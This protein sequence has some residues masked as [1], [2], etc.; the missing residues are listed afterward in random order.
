MVSK[1]QPFDD[2]RGWKASYCRARGDGAY[3]VF[4]RVLKSSL[5]LLAGLLVALSLWCVVLFVAGAS[6][7]E[8]HLG[9]KGNLVLVEQLNEYRLDSSRVREFRL[10]S[11]TGLAV[12]I[13][14]RY[15]D[16]PLEARPLLLMMGG[17]ETGRAA[18]D[19]IPDTHGVA[20]AAISYPFGVVPHR[21]ALGML[22]SLRRIQ[23]GI[24]DTPAATLLALDYLVSPASGL[25]P[26]SV[27]LAGISFGA[28]L[29]SVPAALDQR[30]E[31]LWLIHGSAAV[32]D[33]LE[34]GLR[35]RIGWEALRRPIAGYLATVAGA[36]RLGPERWVHRVAPRPLVLVHAR[37]DR[38]VPP[39]ATR[40]LRDLA[41]G[42]VE[43]L[44][45]PGEHVHPKRPAV[46]AAITELMFSRIAGA[47]AGQ[48]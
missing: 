15:P 25:S 20:L 27:E 21:E 10:H 38:N 6:A 3:T 36:D 34:H 2:N 32:P 33:V 40:A 29:A 19:V 22:L 30:V 9:R 11:D 48:N 23:N 13:A 42:P 16:Q 1:K 24:F 26:G 17:Q 28:Y 47:P 12:E 43:V 44:W 37:A 8:D 7:P 14:V 35:K 41:R 5:Y 39:A 45:T 18:V 4:T 46:I 31:R